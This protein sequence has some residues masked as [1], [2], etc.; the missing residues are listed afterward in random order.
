[1][2]LEF[3]LAGIAVWFAFAA[4]VAFMLHM[5][6]RADARH[7]ELVATMRS[8]TPVPAQRPSARRMGPPARRPLTSLGV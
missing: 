2:A 8:A 3:V 4:S 1:M 6:S 5:A 7:A